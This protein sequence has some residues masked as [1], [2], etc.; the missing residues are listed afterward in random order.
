MD[1][2]PGSVGG[3]ELA[4]CLT[5]LAGGDESVGERSRLECGIDLSFSWGVK[6]PSFDARGEALVAERRMR[7]V[8]A[9]L[10]RLFIIEELSIAIRK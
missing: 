4:T 9:R 8:R 10:R 7:D 5:E 2:R 3:A 1:D 6:R